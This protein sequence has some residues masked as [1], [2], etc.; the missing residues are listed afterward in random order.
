MDTL[1]HIGH[2]SS[3]GLSS[4]LPFFW[5]LFTTIHLRLLHLGFSSS[6]T[7]FFIYSL[8]HLLSSSLTLFTHSLLH[9]NPL[10]HL[11]S[12]LLIGHFSS[13]WTLP[14]SSLFYL[15]SLGTRFFTWVLVFFTWSLFLTCSSLLHLGFSSLLTLFF[16]WAL[17]FIGDSRLHLV[18]EK[19]LP[20]CPSPH[21]LVFFTYI[22]FSTW[23]SL[24]HLFLH[25][26]SIL[27]LGS[28]LHIGHSV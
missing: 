4:S 19:V 13:H 1:L 15:H 20:F 7:L 2:S 14:F 10:F 11:S 24:L 25:S 5:D 22:F 6:L 3:L 18:P 21:P 12:L 23:H 17:F 27:H 8:L 9:L 28:L 16:T 26:V